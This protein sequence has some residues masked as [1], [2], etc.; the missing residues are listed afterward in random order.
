MATRLGD[1]VV[2]GE[3]RNPRWSSTFGVIA[4][5]GA[6]PGD[7]T[8]IRVDLTGDCDEDLRGKTFRFM[9]RKVD[10]DDPVFD[11]KEQAGFRDMQV[12]TTGTM[13]A[14]SWVRTFDCSMEEFLQRSKLGEP[15]PTEWKRRLYLEWFSQNGRVVIEMADPIVEE[16]VREPEGED[17]EGDWIPLP[18]QAL[19]PDLEESEP[20]GGLEVTSINIAD[21]KPKIETWTPSKSDY[22]DDAPDSGLQRQLD[23]EAA[24]IDRAVS[25]EDEE[26]DPLYEAKLMDYC[27]DHAEERPLAGIVDTSSLKPDEQLDDDQVESAL[28]VLLGQLA[29]VG[30]ALDVC[31][32]FSPRDCYRLLREKVLDE[33]SRYTELIGSG[34]VQH[35]CT[36]EHCQAC[37]AEA[38]AKYKDLDVDPPQ[39]GSS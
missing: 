34:W 32:H 29:F 11:P 3:L 16:C 5:R 2:Y 36:W 23:A 13:T 38:E 22:D 25:G 30:V 37:E 27:I 24:A 14:E 1:Y 10:Q 26:E 20:A 18:H 21:G 33:P 7:E 35:I 19:H 4:L 17:D 6:A 15:P 8:V 28:K 9:P 12:G 31:E 39:N